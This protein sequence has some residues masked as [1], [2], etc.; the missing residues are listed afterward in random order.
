M[1]CYQLS[2]KSTSLSFLSSTSSTSTPTPQQQQQKESSVFI[3]I[4]VDQE[5]AFTVGSPV[6]AIQFVQWIEPITGTSTSSIPQRMYCVVIACQDGTV[7][8]ITFEITIGHD[9]IITFQNIQ[10][11][12]IIIDGPIV[13]IFVQRQN[14]MTTT[15]PSSLVHVTVGSLC[16]YVAELYMNPYTMQ[17]VPIEGPSMVVQGFWN[18]RLQVEDSILTVYRCRNYVCIGTQAGRCYIYQKIDHSINY[19]TQNNVSDSILTEVS[20]ETMHHM[21]WSC[22]LPYPIHAIV[23]IPGEKLLV[24]TRRTVHLFRHRICRTKMNVAS[25]V[26]TANKIKDRIAQLRLQTEEKKLLKDLQQRL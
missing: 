7:R 13:T 3:P 15:I 26:A 18:T 6:M 20:N 17:F 25:I 19:S 10:H 12:E 1:H 2:T 23:M 24:T 5:K 9:D 8:I 21:I 16:G 14:D 11:N 22:Q 4:V